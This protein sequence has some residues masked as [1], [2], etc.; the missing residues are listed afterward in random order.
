MYFKIS[1]V[2]IAGLI[3]LTSCN[4]TNEDQTTDN[5]QSMVTLMN[6]DPGHFHAALVQKNMYTEVND[7]VYVYAPDGPEVQN[8][9]DAIEAYNTRPEMPT[10]WDEQVYLGDDFFAKMLE[11][12]PGNVMVVSGNNAKKT[13]YIHQAVSNN[14]HV[15]ADKPM[16]IAPGDFSQLEDA[17]RLAKEND[18]LLYDIMTERFEVTTALQ[19]ALSLVPDLFGG[20]VEGTPEE[21]AITK[22][23]VHHY[24][25]MVS[26]KPIK[27]PPWFFDVRQQGEG[28]VDVTTHLVDLVF[29]ECYPDEAIN[30]TEDL[31][32]I[33]AR[34]WATEI[35]PAQFEHV[36]QLSEYPD[37]LEGAV[38]NDSILEV[39]ANGEIVFKVKDAFAKVSVIWNYEAPEGAKD[40]H[41]SIM[42]G[43]KANLVIRQGEEQN[44]QPTLY[45]EPLGSKME[46]KPALE[47][48]ISNLGAQYTGLT[49]VDTSNGW[50]IKIPSR[51]KVGHEAHFAQVTEKYLEYLE[52]G[53]LPDW[54]VPNMLAKYYLTTEAYKLAHK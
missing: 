43:N 35:N 16:V 14:I 2:F 37:Y 33:S 46:A 5:E 45:V 24:S 12:K 52:A 18:V 50:E 25:K 29:W 3:F 38:V 28:I 53:S 22:E 42:R 39:F 9:L 13:S 10:S 6:V 34:R 8:Y 26:G 23:S 30:Y 15:L 44:Y 31:E 20:L 32:L 1:A 4:T 51:Y 17:F 48:A 36:T 47:T 41:Y 49:F 21:P 11:E 7:K 54:E 19:K 40:T 27:R